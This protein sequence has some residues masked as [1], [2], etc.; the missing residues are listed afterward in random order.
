[1]HAYTTYLYQQNRYIACYCITPASTWSE[2]KAYSRLLFSN[3][4]T[5]SRVWE[6]IPGQSMK[7]EESNVCIIVHRYILKHLPILPI[8]RQWNIFPLYISIETSHYTYLLY[9]TILT[10][11]W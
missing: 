7:G 5:M 10:N 8:V 2:F 11:S 6:G 9:V 4:S 1:M 3:V